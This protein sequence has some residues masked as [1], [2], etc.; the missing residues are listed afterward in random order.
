MCTNA[1]DAR[2]V[3]R[4]AKLKGFPVRALAQAP[5]LGVDFSCGKQGRATRTQRQIKHGAMNEKVKRFSRATR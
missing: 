1:A 4:A 3:A 5:Y 2:A